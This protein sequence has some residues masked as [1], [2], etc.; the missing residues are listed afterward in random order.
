MAGGG[1]EIHGFVGRPEVPQ[2]RSCDLRCGDP[3]LLSVDDVK[4]HR[5]VIPESIE[6]DALQNVV[7]LG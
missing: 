4:R 6:I 3:V 2:V 1:D 5:H 7:H